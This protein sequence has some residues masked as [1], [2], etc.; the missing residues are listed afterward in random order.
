MYGYVWYIYLHV[1]TFYIY[2]QNSIIDVG[3]DII[4][5]NI[6]TWILLDPSTRESS[7]GCP[8]P[9]GSSYIR[10]DHN[11]GRPGAE[12]VEGEWEE[13]GSSSIAAAFSFS[14]GVRFL[15]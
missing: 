10:R 7:S 2:H 9:W 8:V 6:I 3:I 12:K 13:N 5:Y 15:F 14:K 1:P 4:W 11:V